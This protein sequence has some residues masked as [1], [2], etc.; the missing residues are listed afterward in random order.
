MTP[1]LI[2]YLELDNI[3]QLP[4]YLEYQIPG[5]ECLTPQSK[6]VSPNSPGNLIHVWGPIPLPDLYE[7]CLKMIEL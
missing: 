1:A 3:L 6:L 2:V 7:G 4:V 5:E